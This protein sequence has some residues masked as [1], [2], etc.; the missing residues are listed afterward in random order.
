MRR[1]VLL[2]PLVLFLGLAVF[3][4][5]GLYLNPESLPSALIGKN[6]P[7]FNLPSV[8][9]D[10]RM[11]T[12]QA[13]LGRPALVNVWGTWC[14]ACKVEHPVLNKIAQ[15]GVPI[16]GVN[17]KDQNADAREWLATFHDPYV[18]NINDA[19]GT[20]GLDLG[21]YGAPET[22]LID[23]QGVIR[24]KLVGEV[25]E[26]VWEEELKPRYEELLAQ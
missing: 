18:L 15:Q 6:F 26:Q 25:S 11:I 24:Y 3:L 12:E 5:R 4:Y 20:L 23:R 9:D 17:Y 2:I 1:L 13:L 14:V 19:K 7:A 16:I 8:E 22:F 10:Q 21:V